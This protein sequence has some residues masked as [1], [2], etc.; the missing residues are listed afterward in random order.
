MPPILSSIATIS[1]KGYGAGSTQVPY[2]IQSMQLVTGWNLGNASAF[3][4]YATLAPSGNFY[5]MTTNY[6]SN[7]SGRFTLL[8]LNKYGAVQYIK[9]MPTPATSSQCNGVDVDSSENV[10]I[11]G[12]SSSAILIFKYDSAGTLQWQRKQPK[13]R[14][15]FQAVLL[16]AKP[17]QTFT[18]L[19]GHFQQPKELGG[20][21]SPHQ[22]L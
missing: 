13:G 11:S 10:Y 2:W 1:A 22:A 16:Q 5:V 9:N 14:L 8:K 4:G 21:L 17:E 7:S 19:E 20:F 3:F 18:L 15:M 6:E 12:L